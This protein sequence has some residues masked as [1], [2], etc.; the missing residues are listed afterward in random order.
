M[1]MSAPELSYP[2]LFSCRKSSD[3][4]IASFGRLSIYY[5][6]TYGEKTEYNLQSDPLSSR[7]PFYRIPMTVELTTISVTPSVRDR[8]TLKHVGQSYSTLW[9]AMTDQYRPEE[10]TGRELL[11]DGLP[12]QVEVEPLTFW[13]TPQHLSVSWSPLLRSWTTP[14]SKTNDKTQTK[15]T[16]PKN[17]DRLVEAVKEDPDLLPEEKETTF[18]WAKDEDRAHVFTEEGSITRRLLRYPDFEIESLRVYTEDAPGKRLGGADYSD[19]RI[20]GVWG[21]LPIGS[22]KILSRSRSDSTHCKIISKDGLRDLPD[23]QE[24]DNEEVDEWGLEF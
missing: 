21:T 10:V 6:T 7:A 16:V 8:V 20:T 13:L 18:T 11:R 23:E 5:T 3:P 15:S 1:A 22:L 14:M 12:Q 4:S 19:G 17:L 2:S 9:G 24:D